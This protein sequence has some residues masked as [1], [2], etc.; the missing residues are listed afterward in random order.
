[1][2]AV[3]AIDDTDQQMR[4][5]TIDASLFSPSKTSAPT[6]VSGRKRRPQDAVLAKIK[7]P[8]GD[9]VRKASRKATRD[10]TLLRSSGQ[11]LFHATDAI[12]ARPRVVFCLRKAHV[13]PH[14]VVYEA[15]LH[16]HDQRSGG[17]YSQQHNA[18]EPPSPSGVK[19]KTNHNNHNNEAFVASNVRRFLAV[20]KPSV[21]KF[22]QLAP[23]TLVQVFAPFHFVPA[24]ATATEIARDAWLL[25]TTDLCAVVDTHHDCSTDR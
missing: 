18:T 20:F 11:S 2:R 25:T 13:L 19:A 22:K 16:Q 23:G 17:E 12:D 14:H 8:L 7:G 4:S 3:D 21:A 15:V 9:A 1:M 5:E 10:L 6:T 24:L